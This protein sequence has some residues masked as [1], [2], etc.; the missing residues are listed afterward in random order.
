MRKKMNND[1]KLIRGEK[2]FFFFILVTIQYSAFVRKQKKV[3]DPFLNI[4]YG[5]DPKNRDST[6]H[7]A[8][9]LWYVL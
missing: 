4:G 3:Q 5:S 2:I 7:R 9:S 1:K 6:A 8:G